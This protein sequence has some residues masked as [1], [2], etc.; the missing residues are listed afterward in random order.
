MSQLA[1]PTCGA[2]NP[3][4]FGFCGS[5][6]SS[7][8]RVCPTCGAANPPAN[9]FCGSCG[10]GLGETPEA[11]RGIEERKVVSMLFA[12]LTAS[13]EMASRLDPED[14]RA[15]LR[16]FFDA[17]TE[18]IDRYG[19]TV[20]KYIGDAIVAAFGAPVAHEDDPERAIRCALAMQRRL[21][22]LND[23]LAEQA[24]VELSLRI[25]INTGEVIAHSIEE[26]IVTG[27]A[28]NIAARF[29]S[30]A[31]PGSRR[32]R[33]ANTP[34]HPPRIHVRR[35]GR[36]DGQGRRSS[37]PHL[38]G[39]RR[40]GPTRGGR[41]RDAVRRPRGRDGPGP[42]PVLAHR[43]GGPSGPRHDRRAP[44]H[45]EESPFAR[46]GE[47][48]RGGGCSGRSRSMPALR[49]RPHLLAPRRDPEEGRRDP[50]HRRIGDGPRQGASPAGPA[51]PRRRGDRRD[52]H[53]ALVDRRRARL[54]PADGGRAADGASHDR[55]SVAAVRRGA[56]RGSAVGRLDRGSA[57]G[58]S[59]A[60]RPRRSDRDESQRRDAPAVHGPTGAVRAASRV[61]RRR[62]E[63]DRDRPLTALGRRRGDADRTPVGRTGSGRDRGPDP[64]PFRGQPL[65]RGRAPAD[66]DRG[67]DDRSTSPWL[68]ARAGPRFG[69][70][71]HRARRHRVADRPPGTGREAS[72]PGRVG[73]GTN[74]LARWAL[75]ARDARR[76]AAGGRVD[77][78]GSGPGQRD[79]V[80]RGRTRAVVRPR[81]D[82][83]RRLHEHPEGTPSRGPRRRRSMDRGGDGGPSGGVRRDP[84]PPLLARRRPGEV[85]SVRVA[86]GAAVAPRVR[87]G[88]GHRL[89]RSRP[90]GRGRVGRVDARGGLV[91][92]REREGTARP[93]RRGPSRLR[94]RARET[95]RR[96]TDRPRPAPSRR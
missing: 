48:P 35:P 76:R 56:G 1:C 13:T 14:L 94:G 31:G 42:A 57:L 10:T 39:G 28:V 86:R 71:R 54:R 32:H 59:E 78:Q 26:G 91:L 95:P 88:R 22:D 61:G 92:P 66:D 18:E 53:P 11:S 21:P 62:G 65:L 96:R 67:R 93:V 63:H 47:G 24:G 8:E 75:S 40:G 90:G 81:A 5:C 6:G 52:E 72:D 38:R 58:R 19:G 70:P 85:G 12:D 89:V 77:L 37:A 87:G 51:L 20:E 2:L 43:E 69:A 55:S 80:G 82:P 46:G 17:M 60:A 25:G 15:V 44:G 34:G 68:D 84:R 23:A 49:R 29:Q 30:L 3:V 83:R 74:L 41:P 50:R 64:P 9:R 79:I 7:L 45:R 16:P 27:E 36:G 73:D 4:G 33:G